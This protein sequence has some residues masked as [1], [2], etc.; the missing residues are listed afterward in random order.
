MRTLPVYRSRARSTTI[1]GLF[2]WLQ[3]IALAAILLWAGASALDI[4]NERVFIDMVQNNP[5]DAV[6]W[7]QTK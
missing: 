1:L 3:P 2:Q 6:A 5:G 4:D 7:Q